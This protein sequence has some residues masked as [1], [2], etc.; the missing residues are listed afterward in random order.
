[1]EEIAVGVGLVHLDLG[2]QLL[3]EIVVSFAYGHRPSVPRCFG[4]LAHG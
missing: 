2:Q 4:A 1:M 3:D